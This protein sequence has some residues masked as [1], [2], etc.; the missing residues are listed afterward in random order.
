MSLIS[1]Y[2]EN[3]LLQKPSNFKDSSCINTNLSG[4]RNITECVLPNVTI[5][6]ENKVSFIDKLKKLFKR[7]K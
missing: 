5:I 6:E 2:L 4:M 1:S 7:K 3:P